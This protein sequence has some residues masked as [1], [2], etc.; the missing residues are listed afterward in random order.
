MMLIMINSRFYFRQPLALALTCAGFA[1]VAI[2]GC[3]ASHATNQMQAMVA[4]HANNGYIAQQART[5]ASTHEAWTIDR[6]PVDIT[7]T[8]PID[9]SG[10]PLVIYLPGL[11]ES[12]EAGSSWRQAWVAAGYAVVS[13]NGPAL[14]QQSGPRR[15]RVPE[16]S[17]PLR[18]NI[19]RH[20]PLANV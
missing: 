2:L 9:G 6:Q 3:A 7:L 12:A 14:D 8:T 17:T 20:I 15:L 5:G 11:G 19:S 16:S 13:C 18:R 1:S 4:Q 10:Y